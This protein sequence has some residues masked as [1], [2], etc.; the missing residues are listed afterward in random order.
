[1]DSFGGRNERP[2]TNIWQKCPQLKL[3]LVFN[4][5]VLLSSGATKELEGV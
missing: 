5:A 3:F 1:M 4:C 2:F